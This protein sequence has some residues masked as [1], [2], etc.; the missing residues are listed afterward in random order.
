MTLPRGSTSHESTPLG[1]QTDRSNAS[2]PGTRS[3]RRGGPSREETRSPRGTGQW[4]FA[5]RHSCSR[6]DSSHKW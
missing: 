6:L 5:G 3:T 4:G 1:A 2:R